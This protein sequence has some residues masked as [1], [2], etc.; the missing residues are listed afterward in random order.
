MLF[1]SCPGLAFNN[2]NWQ[3]ILNTGRIW[4]IVSMTVYPL[5]NAL[6][7]Y[8]FSEMWLL[9]FIFVL[10]VTLGGIF[11]PVYVVGKKYE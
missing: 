6:L 11:I 5:V 9:E 2:R 7:V 3:H 1:R 10:P 8:F 4:A